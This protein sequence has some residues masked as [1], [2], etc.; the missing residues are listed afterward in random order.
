MCGI[1]RKH[2]WFALFVLGVHGNVDGLTGKKKNKG[3]ER[4]FFFR[5]GPRKK[6]G[7]VTEPKKK[8]HL[9]AQGCLLP[10]A[11]FLLL[12]LVIVNKTAFCNLVS[13]MVRTQFQTRWQGRPRNNKQLKTR[14]L[15]FSWSCSLEQMGNHNCIWPSKKIRMRVPVHGRQMHGRLNA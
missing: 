7:A 9:S 4:R 11:S 2:D 10:G 3:E 13:T 1:Q 14:S 6:R 12:L 8:A 15:L 5:F